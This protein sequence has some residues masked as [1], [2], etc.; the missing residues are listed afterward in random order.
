MSRLDSLRTRLFAATFVAVVLS[1]GVS[2]AIG[3]VLTRREVE[4]AT[5][6][7]VANQADLLAANEAKRSLL[8]FSRLDELR[9]Y[10]KRQG[11]EVVPA[12][13]DGSSP[14]VPADQVEKLRRGHKAQ[15]T[16]TVEGTRYFYAARPVGQRALV[17]LR[18][19]RLGATASKPFLE[20]LLLAALAGAALAALASFLLARAISRPVR[21][22]AQ[23]ARSLAEERSPAPVPVEGARELVLLAESF[24]NMATQLG[25]ARAAERSFLLSVSHELKTPLT[26]IRGY[27]EGLADGAVS[28][29]EAVETIGREGARLERLVRDILDLARMNKSEFSVHAEPIDL[30]VVAREA[31]RRYEAPARDF[32]VTLEAVAPLVAPAIGDADRTLQV[33]SNLV[34]NA[35]RLTPPGGVVRVIA[36]PGS[37]AVEDTGPGLQPDEV[38]RAFDRFFLYSRYGGERPV[39]TGLG[40]AI[41]KELTEGMNGSV[42]VESEPGRLTRFVVRLPQPS[43]AELGEPE[44]THA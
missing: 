23:A 43:T 42:E 33:I 1:I 38:P 10:L 27:A 31:V 24:N 41:V 8:P 30:G 5:L 16:V 35:L 37:I 12:K 2:L 17:L 44:L 13:L 26:A 20:G 7:G 22:V 39:G 6:R 19:T 40:L 36:A 28:V 15:G 14:Y 4:R 21:R 29:D 34:E 18:P 3:V 11:E 9:P 25:K 32:A